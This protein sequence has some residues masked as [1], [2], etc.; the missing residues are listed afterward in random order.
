MP[1]I[2]NEDALSRLRGSAGTIGNFKKQEDR[3]GRIV[4]GVNA[5][6]PS[7]MDEFGAS[8]ELENIATDYISQLKDVAL[9]DN[10]A[11]AANLWEYDPIYDYEDEIEGYE[12]YE[13]ALS[14]SFNKEHTQYLKDKIDKQEFNRD[15]VSRGGVS[16]VLTQIVAGTVD[17]TIL[18][19]VGGV[20]SKGFKGVGQISKLSATTSGVIAGQEAILQTN[21]NSALLMNL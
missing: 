13:T 5:P 15:L 7:L 4:T 11:G 12:D 10:F 21:K 14:Q 3:T 18:I 6:D 2:S 8:F 19:P 20:I 1:L 9:S 17:P 16:A